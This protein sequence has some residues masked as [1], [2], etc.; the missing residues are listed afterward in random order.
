M[1]IAYPE[2]I[3]QI[4]MNTDRQKS[5]IFGTGFIGWDVPPLII[6]LDA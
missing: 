4:W 1:I 6:P 5:S 2:E 3:I